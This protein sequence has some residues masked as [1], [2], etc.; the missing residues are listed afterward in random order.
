MLYNSLVSLKKV[1]IFVRFVCPIYI[2]SPSYEN[3]QATASKM[4]SN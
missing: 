1:D 4:E 2:I 3:L